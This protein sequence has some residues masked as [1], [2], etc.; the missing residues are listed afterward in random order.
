[1]VA[2]NDLGIFIGWNKAVFSRNRAILVPAS[3]SLTQ[4]C[5]T[6]KG[7]LVFSRKCTHFYM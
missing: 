2:L 5:T 6:C 3:Y 1:M 4:P 7:S